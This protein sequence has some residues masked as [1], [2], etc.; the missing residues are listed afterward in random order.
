MSRFEI[1]F[2]Q[3]LFTEKAVTWCEVSEAIAEHNRCGV[4]VPGDIQEA[5]GLL[6]E[7]LDQM[8]ATAPPE[9]V[10]LA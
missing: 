10:A 4:P 9:V 5:F 3:I 6:G 2:V 8:V 7:D 1:L